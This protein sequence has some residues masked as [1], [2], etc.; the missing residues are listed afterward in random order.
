MAIALVQSVLESTDDWTANNTMTA[1]FASPVTVG[2]LVVAIGIPDRNR[3]ISGVTGAATFTSIESGFS[4]TPNAG[5]SLFAGIAT[6]TTQAQVATASGTTDAGGDFLWIAEFSGIESPLNESGTS[7]LPNEAVAT[8]S[9]CGSVSIT[10]DTDNTVFFQAAG[11]GGSTGTKTPAES[12]WTEV[13]AV[14]AADNTRHLAYNI[15][16]GNSAAFNMAMTTG[17]S[18]TSLFLCAA[19]AGTASAGA[20][21]VPL[22]QQFYQQLKH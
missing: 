13:A 3:V 12:G 15:R 22:L 6:G 7:A 2:N 14:A 8:T 10:P 19:I 16:N 9:H 17:N 5:L 1:T 18:R 11:C 21:A 4:V 20:N